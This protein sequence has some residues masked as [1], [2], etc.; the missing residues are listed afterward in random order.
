MILNMQELTRLKICTNFILKNSDRAEHLSDRFGLDSRRINNNQIFISLEPDM[1]KNIK[2]INHAISEG[3]SGFI[4]PFC[5]SRQKIR[6][7]IPFLI[8]RSIKKIYVELLKADFEEKERKPIIIGITGTNGK[9][10]TALL[11][12]QSLI[13]QN[14]KVGVISSEGSGIYPKLVANEYTTPPI[15]ICYQYQRFFC[16]KKCDYVI[17]ECSSQGLHQGR[18]DGIQFTYSIITNIDEDH[19]EYHKS[20][21]NYINSKL[22]ILNQSRTSIIN[23]DSKNLKK[24]NHLKYDCKRI[25]YISK[26]KVINKK[27]INTSLRENIK[28]SKNFNLYSL[29]TIV[30]VMKLE[31]F[32]TSMILKSLNN[33]DYVKGRRQIFITR[34]NGEFIIDYAHTVQAYKNIFRDFDMSKKVCTLFGCGGD[35]D[36]LKRKRTGRIVDQ[37]SSKIIIT[38]DNSRTEQFKKILKDILKGI[39]NLDKVKIIKSRKKAIRYMLRIS[40]DDQLNF[41]MGKGNENYILA[42]NKKIKHNDINY[43]KSILRNYEYKTVKDC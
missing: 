13:Y 23:L 38:E 1:K 22:K 6:S 15:D 42:N 12:A 43:L 16:K 27:I 5:V 28:N 32:N 4:T 33:L 31:K 20:L 2:N 10:S 35:R 14:K 26:N 24:I 8:E 11:L 7:S 34:E 19:I 9:T 30:A 29:L 21:K 41:I 36:K 3:A 17:I 39:R 18:L 40:S 37:F 25:F